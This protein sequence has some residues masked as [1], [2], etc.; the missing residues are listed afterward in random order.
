MRG[1]SIHLE[2]ER[3]CCVG[4][5]NVRAFHREVNIIDGQRCDVKDVFRKVLLPCCRRTSLESNSSCIIEE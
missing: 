5:D 2:M 4:I 1:N 3:I